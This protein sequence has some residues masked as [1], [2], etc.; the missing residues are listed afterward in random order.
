MPE[1]LQLSAD[2]FKLKL[3]YKDPFLKGVIYKSSAILQNGITQNITPVVKQ[4]KNTT[5]V[6]AWPKL[7]YKGTIK[8]K[9]SNKLIAILEINGNEALLKEGDE[10]MQVDLL[11]IYSDSAFVG[12]EKEKKFIVK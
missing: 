8:N 3:N 10:Y 6:I 11:K 12:F 2:S 7:I 9:N 4:V 1:N 5:T